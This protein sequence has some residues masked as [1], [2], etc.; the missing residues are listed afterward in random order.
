[1]KSFSYESLPDLKGVHM[2]FDL[3]NDK[4]EIVCDR[5][6]SECRH[7]LQSEA[8]GL[9]LEL[10]GKP[11]ATNVID[12]VAEVVAEGGHEKVYDAVHRCAPTT[13]TWVSTNWDD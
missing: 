9:F 1:M 6:S 7:E 4:V 3:R 11:E 8:Y 12:A 13:F 10:I 2:S 5:S